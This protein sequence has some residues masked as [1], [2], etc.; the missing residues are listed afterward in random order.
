MLGR[1]TFNGHKDPWTIDRQA[2]P[3]L[4]RGSHPM[5]QNSIVQIYSTQLANGDILRRPLVGQADIRNHV[6]RCRPKA[7]QLVWEIAYTRRKE[8]GVECGSTTWRIP[9]GPRLTRMAAHK[10]LNFIMDPEKH[11]RSIKLCL[12]CRTANKASQSF[13]AEKSLGTRRSIPGRGATLENLI[14]HFFSYPPK[15]QR[16]I[17]V[18]GPKLN[19]G[20]LE[21]GF[22]S[23]P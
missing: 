11:G 18:C 14:Y 5:L 4:T 17:S 2:E 13:L 22:R 8:G 19:L 23:E 15:L 6:D 1:S 16:V 12:L 21:S 9:A 3:I 7:G 10:F 20:I